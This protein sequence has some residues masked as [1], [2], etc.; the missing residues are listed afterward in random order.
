[1]KERLM[2]TYYKRVHHPIL[3]VQGNREHPRNFKTKSVSFPVN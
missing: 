3:T 1:M 2:L